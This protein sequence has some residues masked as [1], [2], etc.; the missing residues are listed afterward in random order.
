MPITAVAFDFGGVLSRSPRE[1][2]DAYAAE[3]GL[4]TGTFL[5]FFRGDERMA[6]LETGRISSREFFKY[7]CVE[8]QG[9]HEVRVD[10]RALAGAAAAGETLDPAMLEL[11]REVREQCAT[12][13]LTNNVREAGWRTGFPFELFDVVVDSSEVG[14]RKPD[15]AIYQAL[16][17]RLGRPA[18]EVAFVD[19]FTENLPPAAALGLSTIA[20]VDEAQCRAELARLGLAA[21]A[22]T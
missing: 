3:L 13:L 9:R 8:V 1:A 11:V 5:P 18:H 2:L 19:D 15:P 12:A 16:L 6:E 7:V 10:I 21:V 14:V 22:V 20:F 17:A 4:P